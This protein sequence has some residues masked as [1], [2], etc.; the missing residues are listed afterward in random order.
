MNRQ[1]F[2]RLLDKYLEGNASDEEQ[3]MLYAYYQNAQTAQDWDEE[4]MGNK[5]QTSQHMWRR[6]EA[7]IGALPQAATP[8]YRRRWLQAAAA[9]LAVVCAGAIFWYGTNTH[10]PHAAAQ[11]GSI[12]LSAPLHL[13]GAVLT[14]SDGTNIM[15]DNIADG[16]LARQG[17]TVVKK[18][19][20]KIVYEPASEK[21]PGSIAETYNRIA[22]AKG[23][24]YQI[25][26]P[27]GSTAWLNA[28]SALRFPAANTPAIRR[29]EIEGE[30]Y[31]EVAKNKDRPFRVAVRAPAA[32]YNNAVVEVLG[33]HF[34][35]N[36]YTDEKMLR[37][38]LLEG[39]L[40]VHTSENDSA[41]RL[42]VPGQQAQMHSAAAIAVKPVNV[43]QVVAWQK[44][45]FDFRG[46]RT[47]E[48]MRQLARWYDIEVIFKS[49]EKGKSFSG[50]LSRNMALSDVLKILEQG[51]IRMAVQGRTITVLS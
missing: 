50:K 26:L 32:G 45:L 12:R 38:T 27:D 11:A 42:L 43:A 34:N 17:N 24:Q 40:K 21:R 9:V 37:A 48:V 31:F 14:L 16:V 23:A 20:R 5:A 29:V 46:A 13:Q 1:E 28:A 10:A 30:V 15:L 4:V 49:K 39:S 6:L 18:W 8:L 47:G 2:I 25:V 36:A 19:G 51:G 35:I 7:A 41:G 33:T 22:T 3:A 44:G